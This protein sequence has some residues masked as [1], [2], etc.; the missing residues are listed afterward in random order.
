MSLVENKRFHPEIRLK[1]MW[2]L[3]FS[4]HF[5]RMFH[6]Y[7]A[8]DSMHEMSTCYNLLREDTSLMYHSFSNFAIEWH[9]NELDEFKNDGIK[10]RNLHQTFK[11]IVDSFFGVCILAIYSSNNPHGEIVSKK[12]LTSK[13]EMYHNNANNYGFRIGKYSHYIDLMAKNERECN[14]LI[15]MMSEEHNNEFWAK[16][17]KTSYTD[18]CYLEKSGEHGQLEQVLTFEPSILPKEPFRVMLDLCKLFSI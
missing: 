3:C 11:Q 2:K 12:V 18:Q 4:S 10:Q 8:K 15:K 16:S 5:L 13:P 6:H 9:L 1:M 7:V 14:Q 17:L